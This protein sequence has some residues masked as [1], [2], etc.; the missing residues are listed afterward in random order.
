MRTITGFLPERT[1]FWALFSSI[2]RLVVALHDRSNRR[3]KSAINAGDK[4]NLPI[5]RFS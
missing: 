4:K 1:G 2:S 5:C 3:G